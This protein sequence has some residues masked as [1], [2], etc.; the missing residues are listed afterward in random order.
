MAL[1]LTEIP[2][3]DSIILLPSLRSILMNFKPSS[4]DAYVYQLPLGA[5]VIEITKEAPAVQLGRQRG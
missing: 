5:H 1:F 3:L 4:R 2:I